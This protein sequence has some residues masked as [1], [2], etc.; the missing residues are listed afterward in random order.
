MLREP[1]SGGEPTMGETEHG[2]DYT[3][4]VKALNFKEPDRL[5]TME[6]MVDLPVQEQFLG[7]KIASVGDEIEFYI[8]AG[9]DFFYQ[10]ARFE[11][12]GIPPVLS[13]GSEI[14]IDAQ[15]DHTDISF[16]PHK[17]ECPLK[18]REGFA[19][20]KWPDPDAI[21]Y[22]NMDYV[23]KAVPEGM[24]IVA[25]VGG[26][27]ARSWILMGFENFCSGV[28]RDPDYVGQVFE[29]IG[30]VSVELARRLVKKPKVFALWYSD[31]F[32]HADAPMISPN[33]VRKY[34]FPYMKRMVE[35]THNAGLPFI[36]HG[37]GNVLPLLDDLL[38]MGIDALHPIE[39]KAINIYELKEKLYG[40]VAIIGNVSV[41]LLTN[42]TPE[43]IE[44]DVKEHIQRLA[45]GGG[46]II[47]SSNSIAY[48]IPVEN[49]R[50]FLNCIRKYGNYPINI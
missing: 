12:P 20:Y 6:L 29:A 27:F 26:I 43:K 40:K 50:V 14:R 45:P 34:L 17:G 36:Y 3:R 41:D 33:A 24:G 48:Y 10:K 11:F 4:I 31:D 39:P 32:A 21:D 38:G 35:I 46:Y 8:K 15:K 1:T 49:Y 30:N 19:K 44:S 18:N 37:C 25:G 5:P 47:S 16:D 13:F 7:R 23:A 2:P 9:Y 28:L 42:G 22:S